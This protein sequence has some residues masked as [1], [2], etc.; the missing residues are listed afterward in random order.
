MLRRIFSSKIL[1]LIPF[2]SLKTISDCF[3]GPCLHFNQWWVMADSGIPECRLIPDN[4]PPD[5]KHVFWSPHNNGLQRCYRI[6]DR[7]PC[8]INEI[9]TRKGLKIY[10]SS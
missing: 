10:C 5:G 3:K 8:P 6:G 4:C 9:I 1:S 2:L 7:G